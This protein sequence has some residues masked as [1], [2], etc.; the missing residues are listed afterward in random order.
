MSLN[1]FIMYLQQL[2]TMVESKNEYSVALAKNALSAT[3]SLAKI[4]GKADSIT[5][6]TMNAAMARFDMLVESKKDF[7]GKPGDVKGNEIKRMRLQ[8]TLF[9]S[10]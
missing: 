8:T 3:V 2:L 7:A 5:L 9:P 1:N 10:C 4:S 6:R